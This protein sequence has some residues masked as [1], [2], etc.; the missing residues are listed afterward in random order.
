[1]A[2]SL[3]KSPSASDGSTEKTEPTGYARLARKWSR[4]STNLLASGLVIV[5]AIALVRHVAPWWKEDQ[6]PSAKAHLSETVGQGIQTEDPLGVLSG[7][8]D[9]AYSLRQAHFAGD[10]NGAREQLRQLCRQAANTLRESNRPIGPAEEQLLRRLRAATPVAMELRKWRMYETDGPA[11]IV[12]ILPWN[13][14]ESERQSHDKGDTGGVLAWGVAVPGADSNWTLF[15]YPGSQ[16]N[17][18]TTGG[19][20]RIELPVGTTTTMSLSSENGGAMLA[21]SGSLDVGV[22]RQHFDRWARTTGTPQ[23]FPWRMIGQ[24]WLARFGDHNMGWMDV[25]LFVEDGRLNGGFLTLS[26]GPGSESPEK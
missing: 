10:R 12:A 9:L 7:F 11:P 2:D 21:F 26:G 18:S 6:P 15:A 22:C 14:L 25:H 17:V 5:A 4:L 19:V 24:Q 3:P 16:T 23:I 1:M 20:P 13:G 8:G